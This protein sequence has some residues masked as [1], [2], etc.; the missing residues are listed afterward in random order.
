MNLFATNQDTRKC[1][2]LQSYPNSAHSWQLLHNSVNGRICVDKGLIAF[3]LAQGGDTSS[4][5]DIEIRVSN[6]GTL[7]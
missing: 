5:Y 3:E 4:N 2:R 6:W 1:D 7:I